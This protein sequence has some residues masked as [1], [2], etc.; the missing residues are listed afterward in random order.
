M[1]TKFLPATAAPLSTTPGHSGPAPIDDGPCAGSG[2][3]TVQTRG[4]DGEVVPRRRDHAAAKLAVRAMVAAP[5]HAAVTLAKSPPASRQDDVSVQ[6]RVAS[7]RRHGEKSSPPDD[8]GTPSAKAAHGAGCRLPP[9]RLR[10]TL[11]RAD[12]D[13]RGASSTLRAAST[14]PRRMR[15]RIA[16]ARGLLR[17]VVRGALEWQLNFLPKTGSRRLDSAVGHAL[18]RRPGARASPHEEFRG[19][20]RRAVPRLCQCAR[21]ARGRQGARRSAESSATPTSSAA[22]AASAARTTRRTSASCSPTSAPSTRTGES[23]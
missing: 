9:L 16:G 7:A 5:I 21:H 23:Q 18:D 10:E 20:R 22:R 3:H 19:D 6:A 1:F 14:R 15:R 4:G 12:R 13:L 11:R 8:A 2:R 17:G